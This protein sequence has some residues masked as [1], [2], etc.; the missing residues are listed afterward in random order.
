MILTDMRKSIA[1]VIT[2]ERL[3]QI[4]QEEIVRHHLMQEGMW[5]DVK[6]GVKKLSS[7]VSKKFKS[8]AAEWGSK[9]SEK[10]EDLSEMPEEVKLVMDA[11]KAGMKESGESLK[12]DDNLKTAKELS[13]LDVMSIASEDLSGPIK[14]KAEETQKSG[15]VSEACLIVLDKSYITERKQLNEFGVGAAVGVGLATLGGL[16]LL[17]KGLTKLAKALGSEKLVSVFEKAYHVTHAVEEKVVDYIVPDAL[18]YQIYKFLNR[19]G[20][21]VTKNKKLLTFEQYRSDADKSGARKKTDG[22]VYKVV[23]IY[24]AFQGLLGVLKAGASLL[25]FVE[26]GATAVKGAE[27]AVG[28]S[29]VAA[30]VRGAETAAA[31]VAAAGTAAATV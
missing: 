19:R 15:K 29:E 30:I 18:S 3:R 11:V 2:E 5:D 14:D 20:Y 31:G 24:F 22:L 16:P 8:A 1:P 12:L 21:H 7:Y 13:K 25:G 23:L 27:L 6:D 9:I 4:I 10:L 28:A 17:F 26:G